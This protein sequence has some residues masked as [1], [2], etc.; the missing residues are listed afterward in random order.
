MQIL[1][2]QWKTREMWGSGFLP[3]PHLI[4]LSG[5]CKC[6]MNNSRK[7]MKSSQA[8]MSSTSG[9]PGTVSLLKQISQS[10]ES[11]IWYAAIDLAGAPPKPSSINKDI[12]S[13]FPS[14]AETMVY[15]YCLDPKAMSTF[16]LS[17]IM[18]A[19]GSLISRMSCWS[20]LFSTPLKPILGCVICFQPGFWM[21]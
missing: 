20:C 6:Q 3:H 13:N 7:L 10:T 4:C 8:M 17:V 2:P 21:I 1:M 5:W 12:Q 14:V 9:V 15:F 11:G 16:L 19:R 18:L